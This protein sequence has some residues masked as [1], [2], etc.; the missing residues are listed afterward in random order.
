MSLNQKNITFISESAWAVE[1]PID[2][3]A[4]D[5]IVFSCGLRNMGTPTSSGTSAKC[6]RNK[7]DTSS[8]NF[9]SGSLTVSGTTIT[10]KPLTALVGGNKYVVSVTIASSDGQVR[11]RK[12]LVNV[13]K[14]ER[15]L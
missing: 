1:S 10:L 15:D 6:Y 12:I 2:A 8:T 4:G 13:Q 7:T 5:T 14:A 11:V 3:V 9:P